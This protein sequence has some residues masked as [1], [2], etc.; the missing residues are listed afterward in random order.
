MK[1]LMM[2]VIQ[3]GKDTN[4]MMVKSYILL[5][6]ATKVIPSKPRINHLDQHHLPNRSIR[7]V[8]I[9]ARVPKA[10][11]EAPAP[12]LPA[13]LRRLRRRQHKS[14]APTH[15][16]ASPSPRSTRSALRPSAKL[17]NS[18]GHRG[19]V[20]PHHLASW[21]WKSCHGPLAV[22]DVGELGAARGVIVGGGRGWALASWAEWG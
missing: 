10:W 16:I 19:L 13:P 22:D 2:M 6:P 9:Q 20:L 14:G 5:F 15:K 11:N 12:K 18:S 7:L 4:R 17:G 8:G 3:E 21:V 1:L